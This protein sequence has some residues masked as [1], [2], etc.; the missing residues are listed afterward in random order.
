MNNNVSYRRY[1][2]TGTGSPF[3]FSAA[4]ATVRTRAAITAWTG[5]TLVNIQPDPVN[6]G[7]GVIGYK[8]TNPS[9]GVWHYEYAIYNQNLDRAI[10]SFTIPMGAGVTVSNAGFH[11]PPQ[12]PGWTFD[13]TTGNTGFSNT[14]W[15]QTQ[16]GSSM[17]WGSQSFTQNAN[18]NAV[19]WG[20]LYNIRFDSNR[21]PQL[22][23]ATVGFLKTGSPITVQVQGPSAA[24]MPVTVSGRVTNLIGYGVSNASVFIT[25]SMGVTRRALTSGFGYYSFDNVLSGGTYTVG[26]S[27]KRYNFT[28]QV[29]Q[30]NDNLSNLDFV[31]QP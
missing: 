23:N 6:D 20:T 16:D 2:V 22:M 26:V 21:P 29:V 3:A 28:S 19:R 12:Q 11:A 9:A 25:D 5:A 13:G 18:A 24:P 4:A 10:Q 14:P 17:T 7:I 27:S 31:A 8:V 30:I 15:A 1:T